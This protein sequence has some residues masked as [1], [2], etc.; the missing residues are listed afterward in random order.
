LFNLG[1][2]S[3]KVESAYSTYGFPSNTYKLR[4]VWERK[5]LG[6]HAEV[7]VELPAHGAVLLELKP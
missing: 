4:D 6:E 5:E 7:L 1:D 2:S 3:V